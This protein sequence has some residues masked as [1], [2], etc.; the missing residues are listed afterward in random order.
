MDLHFRVS[1]VDPAEAYHFLMVTVVV[2]TVVATVAEANRR[3]L[4]A[5]T[6]ITCHLRV[7][8]TCSSSFVS[9]RSC[10]SREHITAAV[11]ALVSQ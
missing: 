8:T 10:G 5:L 6:L 7:L 3:P 9:S 2:A 1:Q 4:G 11:L